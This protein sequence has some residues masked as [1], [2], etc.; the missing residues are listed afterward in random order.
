MNFDSVVLFQV[1]GCCNLLCVTLDSPKSVSLSFSLPFPLWAATINFC[2]FRI[3]FPSR[4]EWSVKSNLR[5]A[6]PLIHNF[7]G[8]NYANDRSFSDLYPPASVDGS[9][10]LWQ[11]AFCFHVFYSCVTAENLALKGWG[12]HLKRQPDLLCCSF[13]FALYL[14]MLCM[15]L[16]V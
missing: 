5:I 6:R 9:L 14:L 3:T 13:S 4:D 11:T 10:L 2:V 12:A 15:S 7:C 16:S 1:T 8:C